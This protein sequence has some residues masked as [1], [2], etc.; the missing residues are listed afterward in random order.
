MGARRERVLALQVLGREQRLRAGEVDQPPAGEVLVAAVDRV[1]EHA[2]HGVRAHGVEEQRR[3][4][5]GEPGRLVLLERRDHLVLLGGVELGECGIVG[6]AAVGI[7]RGQ[8]APVEVL[9][10][11]IGARERE[12]DVVEHA[13]VGGAGLA[14]RARHQPLRERGNRDGIVIVE[15]CAVARA[16]RMRTGCGCSR[17]R[18]GQSA[19]ARSL[20]ER[21]RPPPLPR[22]SLHP[23]G[24]HGAIHHACWTCVFASLILNW[25]CYKRGE[26]CAASAGGQD[27]K[28]G[29]GKLADISRVVGHQPAGLECGAAGR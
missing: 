23:L 13:R 27:G 20:P 21:A 9:H 4:R 2:L 15:E 10:V 12:I 8:T 26:G 1:G 22:R 29:Y 14:G 18:P 28:R 25:S 5:P 11:G 16:V 24:M 19:S 17:Q 6:L 3:R 7:E